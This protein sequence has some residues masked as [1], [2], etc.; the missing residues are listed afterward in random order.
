MIGNDACPG[1]LRL[2]EAADGYLARVRL[3]GG[4]ID[5][6]AM[7]AVADASEL[8]SGIVE[9]TSRAGLQLRG[10]AGESAERV[11][12][13][14]GSGGLLPSPA[15]DRV[16]NIAAPPLGGRAADAVAEIDAV[17]DQLDQALCADAGLAS[18]PGRFLFAVDDGSRALD[19]IVADVELAAG[20]DGFRLCLAGRATRL[21]VAPADAARTGIAAAHA[22]AELVAAE[23]PGAWRVSDL[24][25]GSRRLAE[26]LGVGLCDPSTAGP[27]RPGR[28]SARLGGQRPGQIAQRDGRSAVSALPPL[29]RLDPG[30]LRGLAELLAPAT[31]ARI[32]P[33]RTLIFVD[34]P[35]VTAPALAGRLAE[36]GLILSAESGW[37]GLSAC[38][39]LGACARAR[40]DV[41][42]AAAKRAPRRGDGAPL[43]HWSGCERRCGEPPRAGITVVATP[44]GLVLTQA[45]GEPRTAASTSAALELLRTPAVTA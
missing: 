33:W 22:F 21:V 17:V 4:R 13:I 9:L 27:A 41:R 43:E 42:A 19:P 29:A 23:T 3:P 18:L 24:A 16:R 32:S 28:M 15:H 20:R 31:T 5:A 6:P 14:L 37:A 8:G 11:A 2:H 36:L 39:G 30:Q 10:L 7:H 26:R 40:V 1:V 34:V 25:D 45:V 38:A 35:S 44:D 12:R